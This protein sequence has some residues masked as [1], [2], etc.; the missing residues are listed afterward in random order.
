MTTLLKDGVIVNVFT[1]SL[2]H[3]NVLFSDEGTIL[4]VG[5]YQEADTVIDC[6]GKILCPGLIDGHIHIESTMLLPYELAKVAL[7]HGTTALVADPHEIA[8]VS[9]KTGIDF[10]LKASENIPLR[11]YIN[12]PS[13]VP[14]TPFDEAGAALS[15]K[16]LE[17]YYENPRVLGLAEV[18]N[19]PGVIA[20]DPEVISK[21]KGALA[22]NRIVDG[23]APLLS[24]KALDTY[25][26]QG[27]SS[28]HE[29]S[30][31]EEAK[32]RIEKGQWVMIREGTSARNL[33]GLVD[34]FDEPYN[35]RCLLVTDDKHPKDLKEHG[36]IDAIIRKAVKRNK[37]PLVGI[38]MATIQAATYFRLPFMGA[39]APGYQADILVLNDLPTMDVQDVYVG[40]RLVVKDKVALPFPRPFVEDAIFQKVRHSFHLD[41]VHPAEFFVKPSSS[42]ARIIS[43]CKE[44]LLSEEM[45]AV[46]DFSRNNG[47]DL[48]RDILKI[49]VVERHR[50]T[51]H[52]GVGYIHGIGLKEGAIASSVSHDSHNIVVLGTSDEDIACAVNEIRGQDGGQVV[53]KNGKVLARNVLSIGGLMS[54]SPIDEVTAG[55]EAVRDAARKCG[56]SPEF[57]PFMT[58]GFMALPVIPHIK[59]CTLGL[60]DVDSQKIVPLFLS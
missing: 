57:E 9:G 51:H 16:D 45:H 36:H 26:S 5:D 31:F 29:C 7:V 19:Y 27:I 22:Q 52:I 6:S 46:L 33:K 8:N 10:L 42:P 15:A 4:G 50:N 48:E 55:N 24:G 11:V 49:A 1:D 2:H 25:L 20:K 59:I 40:G 53:V 34:L 37:N 47:I 56:A 14:S 23:H 60:V 39:I 13:C 18:M 12:L 58:M 32:E 3:A 54:N 17:E 43:L 21:I 41:E 30:S 35:H 28:D 38:R 44:Q